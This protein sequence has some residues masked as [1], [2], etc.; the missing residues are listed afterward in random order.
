[1]GLVEIADRGNASGGGRGV[2]LTEQ[3]AQ[4][5]RPLLL[6]RELPSATS[7]DHPYVREDDWS[8]LPVERGRRAGGVHGDL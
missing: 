7:R 3:K 2:E 6:L 4:I 1:M 8:Q 5:L